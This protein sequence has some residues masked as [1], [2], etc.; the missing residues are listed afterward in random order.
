MLGEPFTRRAPEGDESLADFGRRHMGRRA[1]AVLVDAMQTGIFA[2][3]MEALSVGAVFPKVVELERKHRSLVLG[4]ARWRARRR[5]GAAPGR[6]RAE[7]L[8]GR[9]PRSMAACRCWWT[10]WPGRSGP[11]LRTGPG[12]WG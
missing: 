5:G 10:R 4:L 8:G 7:A 6:G 2:G 11:R 12:W 1:T 3:D 9:S